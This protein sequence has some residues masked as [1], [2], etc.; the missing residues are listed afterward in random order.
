[1]LDMAKTGYDSLNADDHL[2]RALSQNE[3]RLIQRYRQM[4]DQER[5]QVRRLIELLAT[6]PEESGS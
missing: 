5:R 1:M 4:S 2:W 6:N 3:N